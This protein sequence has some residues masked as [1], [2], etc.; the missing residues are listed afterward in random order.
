MMC[1]GLDPDIMET[2]CSVLT[3]YGEFLTNI[4]K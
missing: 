4:L 2:N 3:I 1:L